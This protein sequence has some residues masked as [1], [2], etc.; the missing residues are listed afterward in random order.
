MKTLEYIEKPKNRIW[1]AAKIIAIFWC[2]ISYLVMAPLTNSG[3]NAIFETPIA[4][5][6]LWAIVALPVLIIGFIFKSR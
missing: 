1:R 6:K 5:L 2:V 4:V 3:M